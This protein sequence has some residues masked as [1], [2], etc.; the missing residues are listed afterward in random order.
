MHLRVSRVRRKGKTYEYAQIVESYRKENG[1]PAHRV[2]ANLGRL[3]AEHVQ[4][5]RA[6][7]E[8][9]RRGESVVLSGEL[10]DALQGISVLQNLSFLDVFVALE[11]WHRLGLEALLESVLAPSDAKVQQ[12]AI[13]A[14]L[15]IHR[16]VAP[17]SKFA[18]TRWY[19]TTAL[20]EL[21]GISPAQFHNTRVHDVLAALDS[22]EDALQSRFPDHVRE[23]QGECLAMFM[24]IT[25]TWFEGRGPA[26]AEETRTK[27]GM[28][29]KRIGLVLLCDQRGNPMRWKTLPG[30]FSESKIMSELVEEIADIDWV[31]RVPISLDRAMGN[32]KTIARLLGSGIRFVTAIPRHEFESWTSGIPWQAFGDVDLRGAEDASAS[33]LESLA[34]VAKAAGLQKIKPNRWILDLGI[35]AREDL[36][37]EPAP[38]QGAVARML[39]QALSFRAEIEEEGL[40]MGDMAARHGVALRS[41]QRYLTMAR[42]ADP[43]RDRVLAGLAEGL[44]AN[45]LIE[46]ARLPESDQETAFESL[47]SSTSMPRRRKPGRPPTI[48]PDEPST[49]SIR[50]VATFNPEAFLA[51]RLRTRENARELDAFIVDLNRRLSSKSSRRKPG[52]IER[53]VGEMLKRLGFAGLFGVHVDQSGQ[54]HSVRLDRDD[55]AWQIQQRCDGFNLIAGHPELSLTGAELVEQYYAKDKV[56]KD[57]Q[58]IKSELELR[59]IFHRTDE[60]VRA[61]VTLCMFAL[62]LE[63]W[64]EQ[65]LERAGKPMTAPAALE[66]LSSAHLNKLGAGSATSYALTRLDPLQHEI[67]AALKLSELIGE[68]ALL[69]RLHPRR[70]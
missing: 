45:A 29:R 14:A 4:N 3:P 38:G 7:L 21:Q 36:W 25:D 41:L 57:F 56:E 28:L 54:P 15:V 60:K 43:I 23:R 2:I 6:A 44:S 5:L 30:K 58:S 69:S 62:L 51:Q 32:G 59:P 26:L 18:A 68:D 31:A 67:V 33:C 10:A 50:L 34:A 24:D 11:A 22:I 16:C 53:E 12:V 13:V 52:S 48:V 46:L 9:S 19:G 20:P 70:S 64:I 35:V 37:R 17:A 8:A 40:P 63:R 27:E 39:Q 42:L 65:A 47:L 55:Q 66:A 1:Q 61:H 49:L